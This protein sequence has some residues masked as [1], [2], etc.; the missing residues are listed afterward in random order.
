MDGG[1]EQALPTQ[2]AVE[3]ALDHAIGAL[4]VLDAPLLA[5]L[6]QLWDAWEVTPLSLAISPQ[7]RER[8]QAKLTLLGRL[9]RQT[10]VS[11]N[12]LGL[13]IGGYELVQQ[14]HARRYLLESLPRGA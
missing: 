3:Q 6:A 11:L 8:L 10:E 12:L 7:D 4:M 2:Q 14:T 13:P 9:L 5:Q 1:A